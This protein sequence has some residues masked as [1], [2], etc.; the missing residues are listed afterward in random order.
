MLSARD[1]VERF[2]R[3]VRDRDTVPLPGLITDL[4][5]IILTS[6]GKASPLIEPR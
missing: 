2:H 3:M 1:L 4:A 5:A 6:F